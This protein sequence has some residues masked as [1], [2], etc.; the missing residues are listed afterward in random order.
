MSSSKGQVVGFGELLLR[1]TPP[2]RKMIAQ[3][4][5]LD[6]EVGG[7][8][9]NVLAGLACLGHSTK[10]VSCVADNPL[11]RLA[12]G[13]LAAR[14]VDVRSVTN[15]PGRMG[16][17]FL[18]QGQGLRASAITYDRASSTFARAETK[19]FDFESALEGAALLHLSG[20]TPALGPN[21][22]EA[23]LA[24]AEAARAAG[25]PISFDG[26]FR[27]QLW[28]AWDSDPKTILTEI[29]GKADL[30]FGN[31]KDISLLT[32]KEFDGDGLDRRRE[33]A[34]A[35]FAAF[36]N[37][38]LIASTARHV[39]DV[40]HHRIAARV[41]LPDASASTGEVDVTGIIDRIGTGDAFA[42]G[43]LH[44]YLEGADVESMA[45]AGLGL[46][47]LEHSL[48]GDMPLFSRDD[49]AAFEQGGR[50]VRR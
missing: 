45:R 39:I 24:A 4:Q 8:E 27:P 34:E 44:K 3:A 33:A 6:V 13:T 20:I 9:A 25:V 42:A 37:L 14:G 30:L 19:L 22:A 38:K 1:L 16:L 23:A 7:A 40:D 49:L 10:M 50:D 18:E 17:Y 41:D 12:V 21:S 43:V 32:G 26:N 48:P 46:A 5:S 15:A 35:G 31:H 11:G 47:V 29:I 36:P 28:A 2:G